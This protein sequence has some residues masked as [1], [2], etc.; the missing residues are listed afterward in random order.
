MHHPAAFNP[1]NTAR[2]GKVSSRYF[3]GSTD[4][5]CFGGKGVSI[6]AVLNELDV[7]SKSLSYIVGFTGE[8]II[9]LTLNRKYLRMGSSF[10]AL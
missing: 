8:N 10:S 9:R 1:A 6:P 2:M 7:R 3:V 4:V 5:L